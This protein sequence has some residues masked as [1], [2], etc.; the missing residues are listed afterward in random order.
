MNRLSARFYDR[1]FRASEKAGLSDARRKVLRGAHGTV[2]E[3]GA[4]TGLNLRAYP[5]AGIER[6]VLLEPDA[7][8]AR[9]LRQKLGDAPV[10]PEVVE[11]PAERMPFGDNTFDVVAGTLVLCEPDDPSAVLAEVARVLRPGG[12][13]LFYEHVRSDDPKLA[14]WQDR[15]GPLWTALSGGCHCNR[16]TL[17]TIEASP[18]LLEHAGATRFPKAFPLVRPAITGSAVL[19]A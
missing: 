17:E 4:G 13:Y 11:S 19:P 7:H 2:L 6:L 1:V 14:R 16:R 5:R 15:A 3:I 10:V 18:L 12:H 9:H 8:M